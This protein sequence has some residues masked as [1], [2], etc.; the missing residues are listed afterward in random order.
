MKKLREQLKQDQADFEDKIS[1][2]RRFSDLQK[3][4]NPLF[5]CN[6]Y[7]ETKSY[8]DNKTNEDSQKCENFNDF[9]SSVFLK[10]NTIKMRNF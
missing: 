10:S 8:K 4:L 3:Y 6:R 9:I 2:G 7:P 1:Q 5:K